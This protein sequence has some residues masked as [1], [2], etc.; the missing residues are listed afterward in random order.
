MPA[1]SEILV[2]GGHDCGATERTSRAVAGWQ[3]EVLE[4]RARDVRIMAE[5][6]EMGKCILVD[7]L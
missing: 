6:G 2:G 3:A 4:T 7:Y 5:M 1:Q